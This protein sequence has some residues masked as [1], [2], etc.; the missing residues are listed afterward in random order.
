MADVDQWDPDQI[1]EV[2]DALAERART[3]GQT[4]EDLRGL[5]G[6]ATWEGD[7]GE[8]AKQAID[9]SA[10]KLE[11]SAQNDAL[12]SLFTKKSAGDVR[13]VKNSLKS[14]VEDAAA[15]PAVSLNLETNTVTP[16]DT[17]GWEEEDVQKLADKVADLEDRIVA[18]LAAAAE[19]DS[20]LGRVMTAAAGGDP[21]TP[22]QQGSG[23]GQS[24]QDGQLTPEELARLTE[25]TTLTP[26]QLD[27]LAR[28]N[29]VLPASQMEYLNSLARS[30]DGMNIQQTRAMV[31]NLDKANPGA[32][33]DLVNGLQMLSDPKIQAAGGDWKGGLDRLPS[34]IKNVAAA[35][36]S[37]R[38]NI[39]AEDRRDLAAIIMKGS[40]EYMQGS[41]LDR[42]VLK[43]TEQILKGAPDW[44]Y[45]Q[46]W[47]LSANPALKDMLAA[48]GRDHWAVH[49]LVAGAD[50]KSP[51]NEFI[52]NVLR[53]NWD[54]GGTAAS[55]LVHGL[56][57][58]ATDT[59]QLDAATR[60]GETVHAFDQY[61][62][63]H[64]TEFTNMT[65]LEPKDQWHGDGP[66]YRDNEM[67]GKA[68][69]QL[70][71]A[72]AEANVPFLDDMVGHDL[73]NTSGFAPLDDGGDANMPRTRDLLAILGSDPQAA[74]TL[75]DA[76]KADH[77][78][79]QNEYVNSL[80]NNQTP[81]VDAL[82][83]DGQLQGLKAVASSMTNAQELT[84]EHDQAVE[85]HD[86]KSGGFNTLKEV[87]SY[88]P[89]VNKALDNI[90]NIPGGDE[91]ME[92]M[93]G[94]GEAPGDP[95]MPH[96]PVQSEN[97]NQYHVA[98]QLFEARYGDLSKFPDGFPSY[99]E[100]VSKDSVRNDVTQYLGGQIR[101]DLA[102]SGSAY[103]RTLPHDP[104]KFG[105]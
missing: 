66:V 35:L 96:I 64:P 10:S 36:P 94:V 44:T 7:A 91:L 47:E 59:M 83:A 60:A 21:Q 37:D 67:F 20:D 43:Q 29:L 73:N 71:Q 101:S 76:M 77:L 69:P 23:D 95:L 72:L 16:P 26:E 19:A 17:T 100:Y 15:E 14:I 12:A 62:A 93:F 61:I 27:A 13:T 4:A 5:H 46:G 70:A 2:A 49:D 74:G 28:G 82:K 75:H 58:V 3:G 18:M 11:T 6:M 31:D 33:R 79:F 84:L 41:D 48:V 97:A 89:G 8:A 30:M 38:G 57:P 92:D 32:G 51:N 81:D 53:H 22:A 54:D 87:G 80:A 1:D 52:S 25:N 45:K 56:A 99:E 102:E 42:S 9:K 24:L 39:H 103:Q 85:E 55:T 78:G 40:P 63:S 34:G 98:Q 65:S 68:N 90:G 86:Q 105:N 50:G 88:F 104:P